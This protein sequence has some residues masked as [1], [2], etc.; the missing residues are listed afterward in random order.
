MNFIFALLYASTNLYQIWR[1]VYFD[2]FQKKEFILTQ[3]EFT[4]EIRKK[5]T[6]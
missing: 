3:K 6:S 4:R 5:K 1:H 2:A